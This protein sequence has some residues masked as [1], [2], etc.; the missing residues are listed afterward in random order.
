MSTCEKC[1]MGY[2]ADV[3][4]NWKFHKKYHDEEINGLLAPRI[5]SDRIIWGQE[6]QRITVVNV[7]SSVAQK[8]RAERIG[9]LAHR[10]T[11]HDFAPYSFRET[12]DAR[13]VHLFLGYVAN[14]GIGFL[15][16]C[17]RS[18]IWRCTWEQCERRNFQELRDHVP[19]WSV[20][21]AWIHREHRRCGWARRLAEQAARFFTVNIQSLGWYTPLTRDGEAMVKRLCPDWFYIAK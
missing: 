16:V 20:G 13:N 2:V 1:G 8:K 5:P 10:D 18:H 3:P 6:D 9:R 21:F 4:E 15:L 19:I 14:R 11:R 17:K 7:Q 12:L